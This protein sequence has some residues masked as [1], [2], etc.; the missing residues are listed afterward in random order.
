MY[1]NHAEFRIEDRNYREVR[2]AEYHIAAHGGLD[3]SKYRSTDSKV[4]PVLD[5]LLPGASS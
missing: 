2:F 1:L 3:L 4:A 5:R